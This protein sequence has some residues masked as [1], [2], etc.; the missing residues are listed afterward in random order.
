VYDDSINVPL[1]ISVSGQKNTFTVPYV[2]SSVDILPL[3][4]TLALGGETWH[5]NS[6]DT[7]YYRRS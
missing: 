4:Y 3:L 7:I 5:T 1:Y 2:C 6:E